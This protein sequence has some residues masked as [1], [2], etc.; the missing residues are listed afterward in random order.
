MR[1]LCLGMLSKAWGG[2]GP[3]RSILG[4]GLADMGGGGEPM[5]P[6]GVMVETELDGAW[7]LMSAAVMP[8]DG[9][10]YCDGPPRMSCGSG[11]GPATGG[12]G[13]GLDLRAPG[14]MGPGEGSGLD[15]LLDG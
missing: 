6:L 9:R 8:N 12:A 7:P 3:S 10:G 5:E 2:G 11:G 1:G 14:D 13:S 4:S 15:E